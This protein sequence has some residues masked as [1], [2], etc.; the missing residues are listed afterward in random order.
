MGYL[1]DYNARIGKCEYCKYHNVT[2]SPR[3][4]ECY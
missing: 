4:A 1:D 3:C 2:G